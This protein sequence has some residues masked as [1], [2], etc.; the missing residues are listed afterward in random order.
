MK[1]RTIAVAAVIAI[2][3]TAPAEAAT[4]FTAGTGADPSVAVGPDGT[5]HV[6]WA[7]PN[8]TQVGYCRISP[9]A[10][11]C[12]RSEL[13]SFAGSADA[14]T[15]GNPVV[16]VPAA[17]KVVIVAGC[18]QCPSGIT[19][20]VYRWVS[21]N[22]GT[23]FPAPVQIGDGLETGGFGT[24]LDDLNGGLGIF[25][26]ASGSRVKANDGD[27][28]STTGEGVQYAT[29]GTFVYGPQV[30]RVP[31]SNKL[32]AAVNDLEVVKY[33]V[34]TSATGTV[35]AIN[36]IGNWSVDRTLSSAEP[37]NSESALVTGPNGVMLTYLY[38]VANDSRV[39]LRRFDPATNTFGAPTYVEGSDAIDNNSLDMPDSFQ[40]PSGRVHLVWR[41]LYDGGRL[42]YRVSDTSGN[43]FTAAANLARAE[44][45]I[46]PEIAAGAD[47]KGFATWT[48]GGS[49]GAVRIVPI[50]PQAE[51]PAAPAPPGGGSTTTAPPT[52]TPAPGTTPRPSGAGT[53]YAGPTR[54]AAVNVPGARITFGVPRGCVQPGQRFRVTLRWKRQRRK[55][56]KFVKVRRAD[57]YIQARRVKIDRKAPF[58]QT[59]TLVASARR[60]SA[61]GLR[62]RAYIKVR[63]GKSPTKSIRATIRVCAT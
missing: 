41:S 58:V 59:L 36:T 48:P 46:D 24:W 13:L 14:Q 47:G 23:S 19:D 10:E 52:T 40:D 11:S 1:V 30:V 16:F 9:G 61:I 21:S 3:G 33:G 51:P 28:P 25:V 15:T 39:G 54:S 32:V 43:T 53:T 35:A 38:F 50:D 20:R 18:W 34:Y 63:R 6:V 29:G 56:N 17:N 45:F 62:A 57:F 5:G 27:G 7:T 49:G 22:N 60:G 26:G 55:G 31:G 37:D 12:N 44:T 42:R 2:A 4:P 8:P